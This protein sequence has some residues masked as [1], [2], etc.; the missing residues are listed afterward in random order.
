MFNP[1]I[2]CNLVVMQLIKSNGGPW[3]NICAVSNYYQDIRGV[4]SN[5]NR[6][7]TGN[8]EHTLFREDVWLNDMRLRDRF[9]RLYSVSMQKEFKVVDVGFWDGLE[10][11]MENKLICLG[12]CS[13]E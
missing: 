10:L 7:H 3:E 6:L 11:S 9:P 1:A 8:G 12:S 4:V 2:I 13:T 5:S